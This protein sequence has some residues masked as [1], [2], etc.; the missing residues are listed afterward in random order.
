MRFPSTS[1]TRPVPRGTGCRSQE[2]HQSP[3]LA[4]SLDQLLSDVTAQHPGRAGDEVV[5]TV[6]R[7]AHAG[8]LPNPCRVHEMHHLQSSKDDGTDMVHFMHP[9]KEISPHGA[10]FCPSM[11]DPGLEVVVGQGNFAAMRSGEI[12]SRKIVQ[13]PV[14][15]SCVAGDARRSLGSGGRRFGRLGLAIRTLAPNTRN[16]HAGRNTRPRSARADEKRYPQRLIAEIADLA[17]SDIQPAEVFTS[18]SRT[19][20]W[21]VVWAKGRRASGCSTDGVA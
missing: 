17:E 8:F 6:R 9:T 13:D 16:H 19:A 1:R 20:P 12:F 4:A 10:L 21:P 3:D 15:L 2:T 14:P 18:S 11:P 5:G 7:S